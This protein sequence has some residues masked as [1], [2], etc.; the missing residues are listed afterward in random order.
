MQPDERVPL[1]RGMARARGHRA[2]VKGQTSCLS[3]FPARKPPEKGHVG[4]QT[5]KVTGNGIDNVGAKDPPRKAPM[6]NPTHPGPS[7][8]Q[9]PPM[10]IR[11][12]DT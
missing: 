2:T 12:Q 8:H 1:V 5:G 4:T 7:R 9:Q 11:A 6:N 10:A 3:R